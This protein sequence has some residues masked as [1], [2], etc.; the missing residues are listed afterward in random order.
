[1]GLTGT[2]PLVLAAAKAAK[3]LVDKGKDVHDWEEM[4]ER[5]LGRTLSSFLETVP[6]TSSEFLGA[7]V[8]CPKCSD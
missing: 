1:M 2:V 7:V 6:Q 8:V 3:H 5:F 4:L